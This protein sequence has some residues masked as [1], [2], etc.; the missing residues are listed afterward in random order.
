MGFLSVGF[1]VEGRPPTT[2]ANSLI[3]TVVQVA[4]RWISASGTIWA[5][6]TAGWESGGSNTP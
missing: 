3:A 1:R 2:E 6:T 5:F 4:L